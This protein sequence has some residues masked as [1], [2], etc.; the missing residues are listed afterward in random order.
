MIIYHAP[1]CDCDECLPG[2]P[3]KEVTHSKTNPR[4]KAPAEILHLRFRVDSGKRKEG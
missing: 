4:E 2:W 3:V 1:R